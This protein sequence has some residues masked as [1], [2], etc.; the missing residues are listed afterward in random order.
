MTYFGYLK[1]MLLILEHN[2]ISL[3]QQIHQMEK[4]YFV[5]ENGILEIKNQQLVFE[6]NNTKL[7][8]MINIMDI[9]L[10]VV[11]VLGA[12]WR[13][14]LDKSPKNEDWGFYLFIGIFAIPAIIGFIF[15]SKANIISIAQI[16]KIGIRK[17]LMGGR[18][19][20]RV[21]LKNRRTR[22][23]NINKDFDYQRF[24]AEIERLDV[25]VEIK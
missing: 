17:K 11:F 10:A 13:L 23:F 3:F 19:T 1:K 5:L 16:K 2:Q 7:N 6:E 8:R 22:A 24:V 20:I 18:Q 15:V 12:I 4:D 25:A 21:V 14:F 9:V